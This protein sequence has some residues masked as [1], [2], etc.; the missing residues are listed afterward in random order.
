MDMQIRPSS[1]IEVLVAHLL[2]FLSPPRLA[3]KFDIPHPNC[4]QAQRPAALNDTTTNA[5]EGNEKR[6]TSANVCNGLVRSGTP[7]P[8][9]VPLPIP[10][11]SVGG[12]G[13][14]VRNGSMAFS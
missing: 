1:G 2:S 12:V 5:I 9:A 11:D 4:L 6:I 3:L 8:N 10:P 14:P 13:V 7:N